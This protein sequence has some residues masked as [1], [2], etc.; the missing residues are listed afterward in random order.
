MGFFDDPTLQDEIAK[1]REELLKK[2][3]NALRKFSDPANL[4]HMA[5]QIA[6]QL[7]RQ[8]VAS[9]GLKAEYHADVTP[10]GMT[11]DEIS[12][13][14]HSQDAHHTLEKKLK[15]IDPALKRVVLRLGYDGDDFAV[16]LFF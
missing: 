10:Q 15:E 14:A 11:K 4:K 1:N 3:D 12:F 16:N 5:D 6:W 8:F 7:R 9:R 13:V 2:H